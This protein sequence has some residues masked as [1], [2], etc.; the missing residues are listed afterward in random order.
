MIDLLLNICC[1]IG[2][3][4]SAVRF[5]K[6][7]FHLA[8]LFS[9]S[10]IGIVLYF[11]AVF[12]RL[13]P[14]ADLLFVVGLLLF[15]V[16]GLLLFRDR[17][18]FSSE[19]LFQSFMLLAGLFVFSFVIT[20]E[21]KFTVID[22][23]VWWGIVSKSLFFFDHLPTPDTTITQLH[24]GYPPGAALIHYF[25]LNGIQ[26]YSPSIAY[27]GQNL[28]LISALFA[29][30][31]KERFRQGIVLFVVCAITLGLFSGSIFTKLQ[32]DYLLSV[33]FFAVLW[34]HYDGEPTTTKLL[35]VSTPIVFLFLIKEIGFALSLLLILIVSSDL[36]LKK[37]RYPQEK[38]KMLGIVVLTGCGLFLLKGS[39][40]DH[41]QAMGFANFSSAVNMETIRAS[42]DIF[43]NEQTQKGFFIFIKGFLLGGAD[44][45]NLPYPFWFVVIAFLWVK[46]LTGLNSPGKK[47]V[48]R[49]FK[50]LLAAFSTYV[51]MNYFMQLIVFQVGASYPHTV[52]L[53]R[54]LNILFVPAVLFSLA[55]YFSRTFLKN[56]V[57]KK[58]LAWIC[59]LFLLITGV[60]R[61][62]T[63]VRR[64]PHFLA[65]E[66]LSKEIGKV[67]GTG[68]QES[69]AVIPG[70]NKLWR[71]LLYYLL[72]NKVSSGQFPMDSEKIFMDTL[73]NYDYV[74]FQKIDD[75][76][77]NWAALYT[78]K[79][80]ASGSFYRIMKQHGPGQVHDTQITLKRMF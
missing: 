77:L 73:K 10:A 8:P 49:L 12:H 13:G 68:K 70:D 40:Q 76:I 54:Y 28:M 30:V 46:I 72:P 21:M 48:S 38:I 2:F 25:F 6:I 41:C 57:S 56:G 4:A 37:E 71:K 1:F 16:S 66:T 44:R 61:I 78:D 75:N 67:M 20:L 63:T 65:A 17:E 26:K 22:D 23:Y 35:A 24:L 3:I 31:K 15:A 74:L 18:R 55:T 50:I 5:L 60:S 52:G 79:K 51:L 47:R 9:I 42:L 19:L 69:I 7:P 14:G 80:I 27:F 59:V 11:F 32:V 33:Y 64:E 29:V 53:E 39:W 34:I 62:E 45:L 58:I 43:G 36:L